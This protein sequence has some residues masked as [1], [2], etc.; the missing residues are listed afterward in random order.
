MKIIFTATI[1]AT[2]V[3]PLFFNM[4]TI[5]ISHATGGSE[6]LK[7]LEPMVDDAIKSLE[8]G[9]PNKALSQLEEIKSELQDTY[10]VEEDE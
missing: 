10:I 5:K 4:D 2:L 3:L 9:D 1:L 6:V 8:E 7:L